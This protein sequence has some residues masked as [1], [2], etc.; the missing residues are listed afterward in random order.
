MV[1]IE[2]KICCSR[3]LDSFFFDKKSRSQ[4]EK[5]GEEAGIAALAVRLP[6]HRVLIDP[7]EAAAN[8]QEVFPVK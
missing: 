8:E 2:F 3:L 6:V 4:K 5:I 1:E 7:M